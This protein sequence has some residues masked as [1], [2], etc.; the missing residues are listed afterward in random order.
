MGQSVHWVCKTSILIWLN[1][2]AL[3]IPLQTALAK[4]FKA[5]ALKALLTKAFS[6]ILQIGN[7][8]SKI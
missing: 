3:Y 1:K 6:S 4:V 2:N 5:L 8:K 7:R